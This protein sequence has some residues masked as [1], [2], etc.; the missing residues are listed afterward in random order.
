[1]LSIR[2]S[3][4]GN[5]P[6]IGVVPLFFAADDLGDFPDDA[7]QHLVSL[8]KSSDDAI[9]SKDLNGIIRSWNP[10][11]TRVFG[12]TEDEAIGQSI[13]MLIPQDLQAEEDMILAKIR[14][15]ERVAH[16]HAVRRHK[17]G[18]N[19]HV[20]LTISPIHNRFGEI[21]GASKIARDITR[22]KLVELELE[23]QRQARELL[24][25]EIQH[26]VKNTLATV[27]AV[28]GQTF[29]GAP[30]AEHA[31]FSARMQ[32]LSAAHSLLTQTSINRTTLRAV[33][34]EAIAPFQEKGRRRVS[35]SG[36]DVEL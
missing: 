14:R 22:Q 17:N 18:Q 20:S 35:V 30:R 24:L 10:G 34:D 11:A 33:V 21:V 6:V 36:E 9:I 32:A 5:S 23:Q 16:Y 28:A 15:G 27:L 13:K 12:Y 26:R 19:I 3:Q 4:K 29:K 8:I 7:T 25:E 1:M 2:R 31:T